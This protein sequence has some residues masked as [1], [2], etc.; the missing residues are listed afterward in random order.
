MN[1]Q[2]VLNILM[3][4]PFPLTEVFINSNISINTN[5]DAKKKKKNFFITYDMNFN[6]TDRKITILSIINLEQHL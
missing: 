1:R 4:S 5:K 2:F 3:Y 6:C